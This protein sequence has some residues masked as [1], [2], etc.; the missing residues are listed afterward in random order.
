MRTT[1]EIRRKNLRYLLNS[2]YGG[3]PNRLAK[4]VGV[5]QN[6]ISRVVTDGPSRRDLGS[7]LA[8]TIEKATGLDTGWLDN[9]HAAA[10]Q[11]LSKM[12]RLTP[13]QRGVVEQLVDQLLES[14]ASSLSIKDK[15][16]N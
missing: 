10:E 4:V 11:V 9:E 14:Q 3:V 6:Q 13:A 15:T 7:K 5:H 2:R 12:S 16:S 8:R 1:K